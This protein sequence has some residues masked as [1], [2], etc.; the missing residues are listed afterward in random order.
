[1]TTRP[2]LERLVR[3]HDDI[4]QVLVLLDSELASVAFAEDADDTLAMSALDYLSEFV[5][6]FHHAKEDRAFEEAATRAPVL[7]DLVA[8]AHAQHARIRE[9]GAT[10]RAG[11]ERALFDQPVSRRDLAAAGFAYSAQLRRNMELEEQRVLPLLDEALDD[12]DWQRIEAEVGSESAPLF[13][14]AAHDSYERLFHELERRFGV[15]SA[16]PHP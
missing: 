9:C 8:E 4:A 1:M 6:G 3:E 15:E 13:G 14:E 12:A 2:A 5:D 16:P 11:F 7:R 10:L